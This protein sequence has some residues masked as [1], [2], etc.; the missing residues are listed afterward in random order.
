MVRGYRWTYED[1]CLDEV[2]LNGQ[3]VLYPLEADEA[4]GWVLHQMPHAKTKLRTSDLVLSKG[5]VEI[6]RAFHDDLDDD[7]DEDEELD[8]DADLGE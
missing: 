7:L 2:Y 5:R 8:D 6:V 4:A 1:G 3:L